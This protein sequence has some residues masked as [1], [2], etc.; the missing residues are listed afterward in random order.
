MSDGHRTRILRDTGLR[1]LRWISL[2]L[3]WLLLAFGIVD[4]L[5]HPDDGSWRWRLGS[6]L[7]PA[8]VSGAVYLVARRRQSCRWCGVMVTIPVL[9]LQASIVYTAWMT[10]EQAALGYMVVIVVLLG[11]LALS[12]GEY[13]VAQLAAAAMATAAIVVLWL[14]SPSGMTTWLFVFVVATAGASNLHFARVS[15]LRHLA[16]AQVA[17]EQEAYED[18]LTGVITRRGIDRAF[19]ALRDQAQRLGTPLFAL[20]VDIDGLKAV[21][22]SAGHE[23]GDAVI[24]ATAAALRQHCRGADL[25]CRWGGDE[26]IVVGL[27]SGP[28]PARFELVVTDHLRVTNPA[29]ETWSGTLSVGHAQAPVD[30]VDLLMLLGRADADMYTRRATR[31]R[32]TLA[33]AM[34]GSQVRT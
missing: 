22:D 17:L 7:V 4:A 11:A 15:S 19:P 13:L 27:G 8:A 28:D 1:E 10:G 29:P 12:H 23:A 30:E 33:L 18:R 31:R 5:V 20:F 24:D 16:D 14:G 9:T 3:F 25:I 26:F 2:V 21:N 34:G 6:S 32:S